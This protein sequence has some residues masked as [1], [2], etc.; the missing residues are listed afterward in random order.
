M[1]G[2]EKM[3]KDKKFIKARTTKGKCKLCNHWV[4]KGQEYWLGETD[5][6]GGYP[7]LA[8]KECREQAQR[9][10]ELKGRIL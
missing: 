10:A 6:H 4:T 2:E 7:E 5:G 9:Q 3:E 8:H 1:R